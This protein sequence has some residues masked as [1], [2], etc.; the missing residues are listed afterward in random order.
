MI[1]SLVHAG[2]VAVADV[3]GIAAVA[4]AAAAVRAVAADCTGS[5]LG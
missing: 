3:A 1:L 4:A 2:A 5:L